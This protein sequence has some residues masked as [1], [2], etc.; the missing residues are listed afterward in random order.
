MVHARAY[1]RFA[2]LKNNYCGVHWLDYSVELFARRDCFVGDRIFPGIVVATLHQRKAADE[3]RCAGYSAG[4][5]GRKRLHGDSR[6]VLTPLLPMP[7]YAPVTPSL[8]E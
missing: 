4:G 2:C 5:H 7:R 6:V 3:F 8:A 1:K